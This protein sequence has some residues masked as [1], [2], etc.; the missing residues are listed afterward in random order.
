MAATAEATETAMG[1]NTDIKMRKMAGG[2]PTPNQVI[3]KPIQ[4]RGDRLRKKLML[5][6]RAVRTH[7]L[8]PSHRPM[9]M[10]RRTAMLNPAATRHRE[11]IISCQ[12]RLECHS[13]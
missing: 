6:R 13:S 11:T 8:W 2:S 4:A 9:G 10:P 1:K 12:S 3:A 5:G 7:G